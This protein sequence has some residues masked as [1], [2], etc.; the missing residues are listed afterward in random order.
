M[1]LKKERKKNSQAKLYFEK[2]ETLILSPQRD[3][4]AE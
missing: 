3:F 1:Y 4:L 2:R